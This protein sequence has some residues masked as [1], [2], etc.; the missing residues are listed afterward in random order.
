M[1]D[2]HALLWWLGDMPKLGP[3]AR[4][5]IE[6]PGNELLFSTASP[7]EIAIKVGIG[8]LRVDVVPAMAAIA[9][10]GFT[11]LGV[12]PAHLAALTRL[13]RHHGDP[14]DRMIVAQALVEG[15]TVMTEDG[16]IA[17]YPVATIS[18]R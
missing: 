13:E 15:A 18:C 5:L 9:A 7:W 4:A 10:A 1:L 16:M 8:R 3:N 11:Q 2:T 12:E 17:R 14:F 6:D